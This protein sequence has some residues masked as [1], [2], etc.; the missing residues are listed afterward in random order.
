MR[1]SKTRVLRQ[2]QHLIHLIQPLV[3][4]VET[5]IVLRLHGVESS[6][7]LAKDSDRN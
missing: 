6:V 1:F 3:D 4:S 2:A 7:D 5:P